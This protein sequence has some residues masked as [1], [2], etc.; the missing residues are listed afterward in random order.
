[1]TRQTMGMDFGLDDGEA[2]YK[3]KNRWLFIVKGISGDDSSTDCLPPFKSSRPQFS[4]KELEAQHITETIYF[5]GK[6][7]WK[8]MNFFLYDIKR[9]PDHK[10]PVFEWLKSLYDPKAG[11]YNPSCDGWKKDADLEM[12]DGCG[13]VIETWKFENIWPQQIEFGE[14]DMG[15]SDL[16]TCD[17][18]IRYDRAYIV[19]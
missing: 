11:T 13:N 1:M 8:P 18:T 4:F 15:V 19:D 6:P 12:Y 2:C 16:A 17:L 3:K 14:L 10:N 5:P 7:E 9:N